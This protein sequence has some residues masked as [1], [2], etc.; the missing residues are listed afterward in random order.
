MKVSG[1]G[2]DLRHKVQTH[3][4]LGHG[5]G[6]G[7]GGDDDRYGGRGREAREESRGTKWCCVTTCRTL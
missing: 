6:G 1:L 3:A 2:S 7:C 4:D 5:G